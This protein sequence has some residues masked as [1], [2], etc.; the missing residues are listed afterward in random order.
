RGSLYYALSR[1]REMLSTLHGLRAVP[2][3]N[4]RVVLA[5]LAPGDGDRATLLSTMKQGGTAGFS[6]TARIVAEST[7]E[8]QGA[9]R[10]C[11]REESARGGAR[12]SGIL[13]SRHRMGRA[14]RRS[15]RRSRPDWAWSRSSRSRTP[16]T[17][18]RPARP[19]AF[20]SSPVATH[21]ATCPRRS[22]LLTGH[23]LT[24][25]RSVRHIGANTA[26]RC[27]LLF[28]EGNVIPDGNGH[29][30]AVCEQHLD[31]D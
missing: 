22:T 29:V 14:G 18:T 3:C 31:R 27:G 4:R 16:R 17:R 24:Y 20:A 12:P 9:S 11:A 8:R 26:G 10:A 28:A 5:E 13:L 30:V 7:R 1:R 15:R 23:G 6:D 25:R 21:T 2:G 19:P